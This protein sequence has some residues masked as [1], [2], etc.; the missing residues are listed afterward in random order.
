MRPSGSYG[1]ANT[2]LVPVAE[3]PFIGIFSSRI[4]TRQLARGILRSDIGC[5]PTRSHHRYTP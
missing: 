2:T 4:S 1:A 5:T 3:R